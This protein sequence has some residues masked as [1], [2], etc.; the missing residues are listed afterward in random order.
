[1]VGDVRQKNGMKVINRLFPSL[2]CIS[3]W[4]IISLVMFGFCVVRGVFFLVAV[5]FGTD[6]VSPS[7]ELL[8]TSTQKKKKNKSLL[9]GRCSF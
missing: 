2:F 3:L 6:K 1:M 7:H 9:L 4:F 8:E 5:E